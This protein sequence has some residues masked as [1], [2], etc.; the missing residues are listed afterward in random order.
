MMINPVDVEKILKS[1]PVAPSPSQPPTTVILCP[2]CKV[3]ISIDRKKYGGKKVLCPACKKPMLIPRLTQQVTAPATAPKQPDP[4]VV[5]PSC[6]AR[7]RLDRQKFG[8]KTVLCPACNNPVPVPRLPQ[9]PP[10]PA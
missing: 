9:D 6:K 1:H 3:Q 10:K 7:L 5:C 8:G 2:S 4:G